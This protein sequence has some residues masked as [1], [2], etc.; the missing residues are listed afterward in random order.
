MALL[1]EEASERASRESSQISELPEGPGPRM[2]RLAL[3]SLVAGRIFGDS[4]LQAPRYVP[5]EVL[6]SAS[7]RIVIP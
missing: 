5:K 3:R 1:V 6:E 2:G 7:P 4:N